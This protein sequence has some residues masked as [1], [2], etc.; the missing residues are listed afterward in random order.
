MLFLIDIKILI[1]SRTPQCVRGSTTKCH[2]DL[3]TVSMFY[4]YGRHYQ[5]RAEARNTNIWNENILK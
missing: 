4:T 1:D 5:Q 2:I 3:L